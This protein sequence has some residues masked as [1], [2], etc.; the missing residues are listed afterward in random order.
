MKPRLSPDDASCGNA[1]DAAVNGEEHVVVKNTFVIRS[2][3]N[4]SSGTVSVYVLS[5]PKEGVKSEVKSTSSSNQAEDTSTNSAPD[6][7]KP[8]SSAATKK[9][10]KQWFENLERIKP[11]IVDGKMDYSSI[12]DEE[13]KKKLSDFVYRTRRYFRMRENN[14]DSPL[15]DERLKALS[16][17]NF[18]F[19]AQ[20]KSKSRESNKS[21]SKK[22]VV[23]LSLS[24]PNYR[25]IMEDYFKKLGTKSN[26]IDQKQLTQEKEAANE[27]FNK[28]KSKG[29]RFVKLEN[30]QNLSGGHVEMDDDEALKSKCHFTFE[31][32]FNFAIYIFL[33]FL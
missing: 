1:S 9:S 3:D 27:V 15:T 11:C 17:A 31:R 4:S 12:A 8:T 14:E 29:G 30:P 33:C 18:P 16:D 24:D 5:E 23:I 6:N 20:K 25:R 19:E 7:P 28:L 10:D 26:Q 22:D 21:S 13:E 2:D 32:S